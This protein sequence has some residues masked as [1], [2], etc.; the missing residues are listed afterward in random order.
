MLNP[1]LQKQLLNDCGLR[2]K[3][4]SINYFNAIIRINT[5]HNKLDLV[6][7][8]LRRLKLLLEESNTIV[9][10]LMRKLDLPKNLTEE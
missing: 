8:N 6:K 7:D 9:G 3:L 4:S 2:D 5:E 10:E 1:E